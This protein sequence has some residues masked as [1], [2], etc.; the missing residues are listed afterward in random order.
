MAGYEDMKMRLSPRHARLSNH[1]GHAHLRDVVNSQV[2]ILQRLEN[3]VLI[4]EEKRIKDQVK[5]NSFGV[6]LNFIATRK[7]SM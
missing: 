3:Q 6:G 4:N 7:R 1:E 5:Q 2:N